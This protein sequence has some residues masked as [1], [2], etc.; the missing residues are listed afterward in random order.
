MTET[1]PPPVAIVLLSPLVRMAASLTTRLMGN[2]ESESFKSEADGL[3]WLDEKL[4]AARR[5]R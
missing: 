1:K 5:K 3:L 4:E 2:G